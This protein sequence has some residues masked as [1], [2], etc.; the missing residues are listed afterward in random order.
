[1]HRLQQTRVQ[2]KV[3]KQFMVEFHTVQGGM[4]GSKIYTTGRRT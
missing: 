3:R 1:L 4:I 2:S